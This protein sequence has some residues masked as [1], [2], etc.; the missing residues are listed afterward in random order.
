[1]LHP[2]AEATADVFVKEIAAADKEGWR[3][4]SAE[5]G[6]G[7]VKEI[8]SAPIAPVMAEMKREQVRLITSLPT[9]AAERVNRIV[10][11]GLS[12]GR[13]A[14]DIA[15]EIYA[16]GEVTHSRATLIARTETGRAATTL[17]AARA[18][19]AGSQT[20]RW[21]T[22]GDYDV[23]S[24]HKKLN[25]TVHRW[26]EPPVCDAPSIRGLPGTTFNCRCFASPIFDD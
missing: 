6:R 10:V 1:V 18:Q 16:T 24:S 14:E 11:E 4:M 7:I 19:H 23:R 21:V 5:I 2:W 15:K 9:E 13:R 8:D 26:D 20:F 12:T 17:Q 25:G 3:R 22:A